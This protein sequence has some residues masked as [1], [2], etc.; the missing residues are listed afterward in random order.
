MQEVLQGYKKF[1]P[2]DNQLSNQV[3]KRL[4]K[5]VESSSS[6]GSFSSDNS[7]VID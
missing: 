2:N 6:L 3:K 7:Q 4:R 5:E 1:K